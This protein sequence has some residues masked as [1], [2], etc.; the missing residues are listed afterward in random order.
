[1]TVKPMGP[2]GKLAIAF[3][4]DML[5][6]KDFSKINYGAIFEYKITSAVDGT[7]TRIVARDPKSKRRNL[8]IPG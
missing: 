3:N 8:K 7:V 1:M 6:P 2:T 5:V 4:Q